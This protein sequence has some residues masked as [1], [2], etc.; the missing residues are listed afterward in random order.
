MKLI[1]QRSDTFGAITSTLCMLHCLVTPLFFI[2]QASAAVGHGEAPV[3]WRSLDYLFL[4][5][6][7]LAVYRSAQ[8]TSSSFIKPAL[9]ISWI[10]LFVVIVN[11]KLGWIPLP[12]YSI[13]APAMAL[14]GLHLYNR[15][16]C[17]C[18]TDN[19]CGDY[20]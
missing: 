4:V 19:C 14:V 12:E 17:E 5:I 6:S 15:N 8:I 1:L 11:E 9:W 2:A 10:A 3:W 16:Y 20:E 18:K 13:Y 7:F